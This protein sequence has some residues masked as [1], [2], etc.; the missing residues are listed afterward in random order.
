MSILFINGSPNKNG[1]T[2]K[3]AAE[4]LKGHEYKTLNLT[5]YTIG[6]YGQNLP[7]DGLDAVIGAMKQADIVVIGSPLYWH[8]I[9]GSVRNVLDRFYGKVEDGELSGRKLYFVFQG[10]APEQWMLEAGEY[11]MKRFAALYGMTYGG[12]AASKADAAKLNKSL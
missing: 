4:L 5:D 12:M 6:A 10:A 8:N 7:G 2:A 9:C 11:T 1:N 3:L